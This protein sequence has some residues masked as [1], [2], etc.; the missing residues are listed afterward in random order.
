MA[1]SF[2]S[3]AGYRKIDAFSAMVEA[4]ESIEAQHQMVNTF[5]GDIR[6]ERDEAL[7]FQE[8][9]VPRDDHEV[10]FDFRDHHRGSALLHNEQEQAPFPYNRRDRI[11]AQRA[12]PRPRIQQGG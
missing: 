11:D 10:G 4:Q 2:P 12:F 3:R 9:F 6:I 5:L 8:Y 1:A 7:L